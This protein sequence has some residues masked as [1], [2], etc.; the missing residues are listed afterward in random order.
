MST[1]TSLD[2]QIQ[3]A[4]DAALNNNWDNALR[5]NQELVEKYP[6]DV[7]TINRL[8]R[9]LAE[10]GKFG[11]SKKFY[12]KVLH[13]DPYNSIAQKN[14]KRLSAVKKGYLKTNQTT[15]N[16]K[17]D[18]FLEESG[19]TET[20]TLEDTAMPSVLAGLRTGDKINMTPHRNNIT[21]IAANGQRVGKI[22]DS[23]AK[24]IA[25]NLR[26]G[27]RFETII[28]SISFNNAPG[29]KENYK[30]EIFIREIHRSRKITSSPFSSKSS[31]FTPYVREGALNL[32][33]NQAP[34]PTEADDTIEEVEVSQLPSF[35]QEQSLEEMAEKEHQESEADDEDQG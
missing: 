4:I 29:R 26:A 33:S 13:I 16:I 7:E 17:G 20:S 8:A 31:S 35:S 25:Q 19:K 2:P 5:L 3:E 30:V 21:I 23:L 10:I 27:S 32:L 9:A 28:K 11:Q 6:S 12:Q 24:N 22:E 15:T 1:N 18:T 14:L 34:V